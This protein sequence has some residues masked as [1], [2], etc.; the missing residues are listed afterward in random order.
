MVSAT[1]TTNGIANEHPTCSGETFAFGMNG[2]ATSG[3]TF[4]HGT[5]PTLPSQRRLRDAGHHRPEGQGHRP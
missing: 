2:M 3:K 4:P 1:P 5:W